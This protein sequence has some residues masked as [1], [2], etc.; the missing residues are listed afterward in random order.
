MVRGERPFQGVYDQALLYEICNQEPEPLT[1]LRTG[2]PV[3][4]ASF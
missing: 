1:G 3:E 4:L 2:V